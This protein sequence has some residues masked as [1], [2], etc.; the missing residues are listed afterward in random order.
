MSPTTLLS[1]KL[2]P[3]VLQT[4]L[5][6]RARLTEAAAACGAPVVLIVAPPGFGKTTLLAQWDQ[7]DGRPFA[8]ISLDPRDNDPLVLWNYIV[9]AIR[10]VEPG[11]GSGLDPALSSAGGMML[12]A[13][14]PRI[15]NELEATDHEIV[16]V[17][18]DFHWLANPA[19]HESIEFLVERRPRNVQLVVSS[20]SDPPIRLGRLRA[21]GGL[22]ELRAAE[23][24][25][26]EE[27]TAELFGGIVGLD[28]APDSIAIIQRR[29]E[30]WPAGLYLSILSI[31]GVSDP[32]AALVEFGG[33]S[34]N[35]VEYLT[36]VVLESQSDDHRS[37]LMETSILTRMSSSLCDTVTGRRDSATV[38]AELE[39]ANLFLVPL[40]E[41]REWFRYHHLFAELLTDEGRRRD[42]R[43]GAELHQ[44]AS[45]WFESE[46]YLD[47]AIQHAI[48]G[49]NLDRA[50]SLI[51]THWLSFINAGR[52]ATITGWLDGFPQ[53]FFRADARL[54]IVNAWMLGLMGDAEEAGRAIA[55]ARVARYDGEL[56]DGSGTVEEG[57]TMVRATFPWSDVGAM[58][59]AARSADNTESRRK[60]MWQPVAAM[61]L[62]WALILAGEHDEAVPALQHA[63]ALAPR[64]EWW[65]VAGDARS[66]L[67]EI[68]LAAGDLAQAE[69]LIG[70]ALEIARTR[71]F[72]DLPH[73]GFY[74]VVAGALHARRGELELA[75]DALGLGLEQMQSHWDLLLVAGAL[76]ER[77][78][79]RR[80]LGGR[81]EARAML[82][83]ARAI[84][85]SCPDPG[86]LPRRVEEV[87][88]RLG[89]AQPRATPDS[90]LTERELEVLR[91]LAE[92]LTKREVATKLFLS[93]STIHSHTKSIYRKLDSTSRDA[94]LEQ[95]RGLG[96]IASG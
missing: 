79:V 57:L 62:G 51:A 10:G 77:A 68:F 50:A 45:E 64:H 96:L 69:A 84:V 87:A 7:L 29:T 32:T 2:Y 80:A 25:F 92:G 8:W 56:P 20:R 28:L 24:G 72:I 39:R 81:T 30:G 83:E 65:I 33:S 88:R 58:L 86:I 12:D 31:R 48:T 15:L 17:L 23:L 52:L 44:R 36:E 94:A 59:A 11:F 9:A 55:T 27:E 66:L 74:H 63:I 71:G 4:E 6:P 54:L 91:L 49:A 47:E 22:F 38:L 18:D 19:C 5:V 42:A 90:V 26:T 34:R 76:L 70:E 16:L 1:T 13:I 21:S 43:A 95:A 40:D 73:V 41:R 75:D 60:S 35:V 3:P 85:E 82:A 67:A 61:N 14:V 37:F 53:N 46:G 93:F 78:L 89:A